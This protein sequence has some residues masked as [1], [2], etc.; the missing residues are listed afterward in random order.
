[1]ISKRHWKKFVRSVYNV[2]HSLSSNFSEF[3]QCDLCINGLRVL[4]VD[5]DKDVITCESPFR[6]TVTTFKHPDSF[7]ENDPGIKKLKNSITLELKA[8]GLST[9]KKTIKT[10]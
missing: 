1:M 8:Q 2:H 9:I 6:L 10:K 5:P 3:D 4:S 7:R